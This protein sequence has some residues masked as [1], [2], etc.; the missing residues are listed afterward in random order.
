[1][2]SGSNV[3]SK[4]LTSAGPRRSEGVGPAPSG[5]SGFNFNLV[6][7]RFPDDPSPPVPGREFAPPL[8]LTPAGSD[9]P[10]PLPRPAPLAPFVPPIEEASPPAPPFPRGSCTAPPGTPG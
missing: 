9:P 5:G 10:P 3:G 1:N 8:M 2:F 4:W 6:A 7:G